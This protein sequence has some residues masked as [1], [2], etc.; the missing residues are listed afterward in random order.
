MSA[1]RRRDSPDRY[2]DEDLEVRHSILLC[3]F[4]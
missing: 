2:E 4:M 1:K 3:R